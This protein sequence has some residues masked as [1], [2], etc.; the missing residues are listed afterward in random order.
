GQV[1]DQDMIHLNLAKSAKVTEDRSASESERA[2]LSDRRDRRYNLISGLGPY[3]PAF[4][5]NAD[6]QT[7]YISMPSA[8]LPSNYSTKKVTWAATDSK[9]GDLVKLVNVAEGSPYS[10]INSPKHY[11]AMPRPYR[12]ST[13]VK[14]LPA[15]KNIMAHAK[16]DSFDLPSGHTTAAFDSGLA[17]AYALPQRFQELVTR[18]SEVGYDRIIAGRHSPLAVMGGR[19]TGTAIAA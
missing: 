17:F 8:P 2:Y 16:P 19:M 10:G 7:N 15:I 9:L 6:A 13:A 18:S 4:I 5:Q 14:P 11:V 3:A 12:L 1:V